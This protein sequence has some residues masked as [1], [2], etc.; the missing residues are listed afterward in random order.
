M[1]TASWSTHP[2]I[3]IGMPTRS[4]IS[5]A[6][7][8]KVGTAAFP[9]AG[10]HDVFARYYEAGG[11]AVAKVSTPS[12]NG[13]AS[14]QLRGHYFTN[15]TWSGPPT[16]NR[17]DSAINFMWGYGGPFGASP[18]DHFSVEW[19]SPRIFQA[20]TSTITSTSDDGMQAWVD[21]QL[22]VDNNGVHPATTKT[23]TVTFSVAGYHNLVVRYYENTGLARAQLSIS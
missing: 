23:G 4:T 7:S 1:V 3:R 2:T 14:T 15:Q 16:I 6:V 12:P 19:Q 9:V 21:G 20:G 5:P 17:C 18:V 22:M 10:Y 13:C 8:P 11:Q